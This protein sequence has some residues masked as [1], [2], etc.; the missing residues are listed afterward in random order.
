MAGVETALGLTPESDVAS[1]K[2][3][4]ERARE[5]VGAA[6][7]DT[8]LH[9]QR[10]AG[11]DEHPEAGQAEDGA[12]AVAPWAGVRVWAPA[13][14]Q[15]DTCSV[16]GIGAGAAAGAPAADAIP[17]E[18]RE[19][20]RTALAAI[21]AHGTDL[22]SLGEP[23]SPRWRGGGVG[24]QDGLDERTLSLAVG[25]L[26]AEVEAGQCSEPR[27][28][29]LRKKMRILG[30]QLRKLQDDREQVERACAARRP[31]G[32]DPRPVTPHVS[33]AAHAAARHA[34]RSGPPVDTT[35]TLASLLMGTAPPHNCAAAPP[36]GRPALPSCAR[37]AGASAHY[38][39]DAAAAVRGFLQTG[40]WV[41]HAPRRCRPSHA[42]AVISPAPAPNLRSSPRNIECSPTQKFELRSSP[43]KRRARSAT[44][45]QGAA[46]PPPPAPSSPAA[47]VYVREHLRYSRPP[48][49]VQRLA[50][51]APSR[52]GAA[53]PS[54]PT[55]LSADYGRQ[56][57]ASPIGPPRRA[58][59]HAPPAWAADR[60]LPA[61][62]SSPSEHLLPAPFSRGASAPPLAHRP[63]SG[64][65]Q[66]LGAPKGG[67]SALRRLAP[68]SFHGDAAPPSP[69][70][71]RRSTPLRPP[72]RAP[73]V[74]HFAV[75]LGG[76]RSPS[77]HN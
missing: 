33:H 62:H 40:K 34:P 64:E 49:T 22:A 68:P 73:V 8:A 74:P 16:E 54:R 11:R 14:R 35:G 27:R 6:A 2:A 46:V 15:A 31:K 20:L 70:D 51:D 57:A 59:R 39:A 67:N 1:A 76:R 50:E 63:S 69:G 48:P 7:A 58:A 66:E 12:S 75:D 13:D 26:R 52:L 61:M 44:A 72:H 28:Y 4:A 41:H 42:R 60:P 47:P 23:I 10:A 45:L 3:A 71:A 19:A 65:P 53:S 25:A 24:R 30:S 43:S 18:T 5:M 21:E 29:A 56:L 36:A 37:P 32:R 55:S 38:S 17:A 9:V 77:A